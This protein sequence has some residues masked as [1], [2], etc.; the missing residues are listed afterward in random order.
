LSADALQVDAAGEHK[1]LWHVFCRK[2]LT[3]LSNPVAIRFDKLLYVCG[4]SSLGNN[5][6]Y[7][8]TGENLN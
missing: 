1:R 4:A 8:P 2:L 7:P 3:S 5:D 6:F